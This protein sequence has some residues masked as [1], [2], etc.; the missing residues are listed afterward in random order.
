MEEQEYSTL[1]AQEVTPSSFW[2][3][4][5]TYGIYFAIISIL[6]SVIAYATGQMAS[7][8]LQWISVVVMILVIVLIQLHYRKML[9]GFITYGQA[10]GMAVASL[11]FASLL[12]AV[13]TYCLYKFIDP[14]LI[15]QVRLLAEEKLIEVGGLTQEQIDTVLEAS[16]RFQTPGIIAVSQIFNQVI[17]ALIIGSV[18]SLFIKRNSPD[19]IF[20]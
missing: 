2:K 19:K 4:A 3:Q 13:F 10:L 8:A 9:G 16:K 6:L 7:P 1:S 15:D 5:M 20:D 17:T 11:F 14:G 12:I 18:T